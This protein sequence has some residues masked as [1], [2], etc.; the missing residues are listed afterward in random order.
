MTPYRQ[1]TK[2]QPAGRALQAWWE[3]L[4]DDRGAR[5]ALARCQRPLEVV[6]EPAFHRV[7]LQIEAAGYR[8]NRYWPEALPA[9]I[10]LLARARSDAP[11][12][13]AGA[14]MAQPAEGSGRPLLS[15]LRFRRLMH[16]ASHAELYEQMSGVMGLLGRRVPVLALADT[17]DRWGDAAVRRQLAYDYYQYQALPADF[18]V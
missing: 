1:L 10:G 14:A 16:A 4:P 12:L 5:A 18:H 11:Q 15:G 8:E 2:D 9:V 3:Q 6:M 13:S 7:R 17:I